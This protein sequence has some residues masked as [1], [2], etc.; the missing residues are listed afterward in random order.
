MGI[1]SLFSSNKS[2]QQES[3]LS[4]LFLNMKV[5]D[6]FARIYEFDQTRCV[7]KYFSE[8]FELASSKKD[9]GI[10]SW[11]NETG[12][13]TKLIP[14][15]QAD[16]T[17]SFY[18]VWL[19]DEDLEKCPILVF[20]S[21]G[22]VHLVANNLNQLLRLISYD[23][24]PMVDF[25]GVTFS[26]DINDYEASPMNDEYKRIL[27]ELGIQPIAEALEVTELINTVQNTY[28]TKFS[29]WLKKYIPE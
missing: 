29:E 14:F 27:T 22:G 26:R 23:C 12:F 24:E 5:S 11:S 13:I 21:E 9:F 25:E 3:G 18:S 15:A 20:G 10:C 19:T 4:H 2:S 17:G 28:E 8:G 7:G 1:F 16:A 6:E